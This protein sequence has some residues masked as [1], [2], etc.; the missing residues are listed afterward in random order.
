MHLGI[1]VASIHYDC[2][3]SLLLAPL[4]LNCIMLHDNALILEQCNLVGPMQKIEFW[5]HVSTLGPKLGASATWRHQ[6]SMMQQRMAYSWEQVLLDVTQIMWKAFETCAVAWSCCF[7]VIC[8]DVK[9]DLLLTIGHA[10]N[11]CHA[12]FTWFAWRQEGLA[13]NFRPC[14]LNYI[15]CIGPIRLHCS[16]ISALSWSMMQ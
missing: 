2:I 1:L 15:F 9:K 5:L 3:T 10:L 4:F 13:P 14:N 12:V 7:H 8:S 16:K 6:S 11:L